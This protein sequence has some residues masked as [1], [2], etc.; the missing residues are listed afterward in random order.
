MDVHQRIAAVIYAFLGGLALFGTLVL[1]LVS[2][3]WLGRGFF[4][5][6]PAA[7]LSW[8]LI[9]LCGAWSLCAIV[10]GLGFVRGW[11]R[12]R[13]LLVGVAL[14]GLVFVPI[15]TAL[16]VYALWA[17]WR[18]DAVPMPRPEPEWRRIARR[19]RQQQGVLTP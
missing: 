14:P 5:A 8:V 7:A 1:T 15:G 2:I 6:S 3:R 13:G 4:E 11:Q 18:Q 10:G 17:F 9:T 12:G 16:S 19:R